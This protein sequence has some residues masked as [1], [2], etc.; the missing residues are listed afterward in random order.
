MLLLMV[1]VP[2]T[3]SITSSTDDPMEALIQRLSALDAGASSD[4][5][6]QMDTCASNDPVPARLAQLGLVDF[7]ENPDGG[8]WQTWHVDA[9]HQ[10]DFALPPPPATLSAENAAEAADVLLMTQ[11]RTSDEATQARYWDDGA[12][13]KRWTETYL[14]LI[15]LHADKNAKRNPPILSREM[16]LLETTMFDALVLA[17]QAKYCYLRLPPH[18]V[19]PAIE[20][21]LDTRPVPSYPSE[22]AVVAGVAEVLFRQFFP[23]PEEPEGRFVEMASQAAMSRVYAGMNYVSDVEAGLALGRAVAQAALEGRADDGYDDV[24]DPNGDR[25]QR[26]QD[27]PCHWIPVPV[28]NEGHGFG[29]PLLPLWG[30]VRPWIMDSGD[31][32]R[33]PPPPECDGPEYMAEYR[34]LFEMSLDLTFRQRDISAFW[35]AGQGTVTPP[36]QNLEIALKKASEY[37]LSTLESARV[38]AYEGVA[39]ADAAISAWDTKFTYWWDRPIQAIRRHNWDTDA[40]LCDG[41]EDPHFVYGGCWLSYAATPP[42]PGY[43]SGHS[44]FTGAGQEVLKFFFP[45]DAREFNA[46]QTEAAMARYYGGIHFRH[47]NDQGVESGRGI[48]QLLWERAWNDGGPDYGWTIPTEPGQG[49]GY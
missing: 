14:D 19:N 7:T 22:H 47:D 36:G 42:F 34:D 1:T 18:M 13:G 27:T 37:G 39:V 46:Y 49:G 2:L 45:D 10:A 40:G 6:V 32:F 31:Q 26:I 24:W 12:A 4:V 17:W 9:V 5:S 3:G 25:R 48:G 29:G 23:V 33:A 28:D 21:M 15:V 43:I 16:A 44:T 30:D 35:E 38:M 8:S 11:E 41:F 20:P